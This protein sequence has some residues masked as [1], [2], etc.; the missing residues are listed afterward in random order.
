MVVYHAWVLTGGPLL[1]GGRAVLSGGFLAVDLFFVLSAFVLTLP[2]ARAGEF[3]SWREYALRRS[4]QIVPA[5]YAGG[6]RRARADRRGQQGALGRQRARALAREGLLR[7]LPLSLHGDAVAGQR[8]RSRARLR[9]GA[10]ARDR[11]LAGRGLP[12]V[13]A[14]RAARA[15]ARASGA[16]GVRRQVAPAGHEPETRSRDLDK[17]V[18]AQLVERPVRGM[19]EE[20]PPARDEQ[21]DAAGRLAGVRQPRAR[22][23]VRLAGVEQVADV[24]DQLVVRD[25]DRP[26]AT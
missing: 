25:R 13:A 1:G 10:P 21:G 5:Y 8:A 6:V 3:G 24:R 12:L 14:G 22:D 15:P 23:D 19:G 18:V 11:G 20:A 26:A 7:R 2:V 17:R 9:A 16:V 4:A